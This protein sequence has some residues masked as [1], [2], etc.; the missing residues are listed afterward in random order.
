MHL[1]SSRAPPHTPFTRLLP[2][3][4]SFLSRD[5]FF[6]SF[7]QSIRPSRGLSAFVYPNISPVIMFN[8][9]VIMISCFPSLYYVNSINYNIDIKII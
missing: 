8:V 4:S 3:Y 2:P 6:P 5:Y 9:Y 1:L 7:T